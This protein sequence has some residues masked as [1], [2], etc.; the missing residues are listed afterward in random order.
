VAKAETY[1]RIEPVL[2]ARLAL[3]SELDGL[4]VVDPNLGSTRLHWLRTGPTGPSPAAVKAE[5]R[6]TPSCVAALEEH[7]NEKSR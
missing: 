2:N 5:L 3:R 1:Q 7:R 4:L 6:S